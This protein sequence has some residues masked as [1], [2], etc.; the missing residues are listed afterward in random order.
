MP[1]LERVSQFFGQEVWSADLKRMSVPRAWTY[2]IC[3]ML[4]LA[5]QGFMR[6]QGIHRA[7][8]LAFDTVL[9][10]VPLLAFLVSILKGFGLY[11]ALMRDTI[12]P[13]LW[14]ITGGS[15]GADEHVGSLRTAFFK[16]FE[17]VDRAEFGH[18]GLV[19]LIFLL[20]I[21][22]LLLY[23]VESSLNHIFAAETSR[24]LARKISDYAAILFITPLCATAAATVATAGQKLPWI[25]SNSWLLQLGGVAIISFGL[26]MLY[27]VM[28]F[29]RVRVRSALI[30]GAFAGVLWYAL[31][32]VHVFFQIGVARYNAIYSTFAAFPLFLVWVF[33]SW[34]VVLFGAEL[35]AAHQ[36][37]AGYG[38]RV[39]DAEPAHGFKKFLALRSSA[40]I[41]RR[42]LRGEP[43]LTL[44]ELAAL[45]RAPDRA[46][47]Q[48]LETLVAAG[49]LTRAVKSGQRAYVPA[50]D[51]DAIDVSS[52]LLALERGSERL[53]EPAD[54]PADARIRE[55]L[56]EIDALPCRTECNLT[57]RELARAVEDPE[58]AADRPS[59]AA[60][61][62][63]RSG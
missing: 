58:L 13:W 61:R 8:A 15:H 11:D 33:V 24:N 40:E 51:L 38:Y 53:G 29:T 46:L 39:L 31:L 50:R 63:A 44:T 6:D 21:T 9:G 34:L 47:R 30:G 36:H 20:Y 18:V 62:E 52:I 60:L 45:V 27:I 1:P 56:G 35:S 41:G 14:S 4:Y 26:S 25:G 43:P 42:F 55:L 3:R 2:G 49:L 57:L 54:E 12:R 10:L 59:G 7:S 16:V 5:V 23:S 17:F 32:N 22:V 37:T 28:P 48:V 19:G